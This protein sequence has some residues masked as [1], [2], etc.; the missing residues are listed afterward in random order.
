MAFIKLKQ[1]KKYN[2]KP[3]FYKGEGS[4]YA[5]KGKFDAERTTLEASGGLKS[6]FVKAVDEYRNSPDKAV[7]RRVYIIV[8]ILVL[9]F[10]FIIDF[11]LTIFF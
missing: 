6:R 1:N 10:L 8:A 9:L 4:P 11:D 7:N 2:Y 5:M 3:R